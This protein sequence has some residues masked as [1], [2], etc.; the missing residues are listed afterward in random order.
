M[1]FTQLN[2]NEKDAFF[3]LLDEYFQ[4]RPE[5]FNAESAAPAAPAPKPARTFPSAGHQ[6]NS[7]I[8]KLQSSKSFGHVDT[9]SK[10]NAFL[11]LRKTDNSKNTTSPPPIRAALGQPKS[12]FTPPPSRSA[13]PLKPK[14]PEGQWAEALYDY[15]SEEV[16]DLQIRE[17]ERV[18]V[19]EQT[20]S[21]WWTGEFEGKKGLFPATYVKLL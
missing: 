2:S 16:G 13:P 7:S 10:T 11:T 3:S 9:S 18:L 6:H 14:E 17:G 1:V 15:V 4:S 5:I 19:T 8:D 12:S 21:E 20:S